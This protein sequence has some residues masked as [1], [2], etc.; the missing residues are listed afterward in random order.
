MVEK[1]IIKLLVLFILVLSSINI[2]VASA[3]STVPER[4]IYEARL[5]DSTGETPILTD[6]TFRFSFWIE[7]P[8]E[9]GDITAGD[10]DELAANYGGW[11]EVQTV[12]PESNGFVSFELGSVT[13]LPQIDY[14][15]HLYLQVEVKEDGAPD[16]SYEALDK[17]P[18]NPLVD[19]APVGS[20]PYALNA[21]A[22]DNAEIG[23]AAGDLVVL[24]P[25]GQWPINTVPGG[26]NEDNF[27]VDSDD[28]SAT[29]I[30]LQFGESLGKLLAYDIG[31]GFFNF[32]DDVN[33]AGNLTLTGTVDGID[34]SDLA[35]NVT[36]IGT[37]LDTLET[38]VAGLGGVSEKSFILNSSYE[39]ATYVGDGLNNIG[40]LYLDNDNSVQE[41]Y[42]EWTSSSALLQDYDIVLK[43][44][45][46]STFSEWNGA[47]PWNFNYRSSNSDIN[48]TK[49]DIFVYDTNGNPV[50]LTGDASNLS[51]TSWTNASLGYSGSPVFTAG[52]SFMVVIKLYAKEFETMN[53]GEIVMNYNG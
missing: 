47:T 11:Q 37:D 30:G 44:S 31:G 51:N 27:V 19:R 22:V 4:L 38:T 53:L 16:S 49:A 12:T 15:E 35:A 46:P 3:A 40:R 26:T 41:N 21:N 29:T 43:I 48:T 25:G 39:G 17:S 28:S 5:L 36:V 20:V 33:I 24:E 34:V 52:E 18:A 9:V 13:S 1:K 8:I 6:H 45:V 2:G 23:T 14:T 50:T 42:Y 10:I 32:N 7:S